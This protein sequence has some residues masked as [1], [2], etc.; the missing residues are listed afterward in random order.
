MEADSKTLFPGETQKVPWIRLLVIGSVLAALPAI[1]QSTGFADYL[2]YIVV[3][4][5]ILGLY[6]MS[7][8]LL[9]GY[10][11]IFSYG[12]ATFLGC[13]AYAV[14]ILM[15]RTSLHIQDAIP[16][17]VAALAV[18]V[19]IGW[20]MGFLCARVGQVAV[21]LVS[22]AFTE[23]IQLLVMSDPLRI[24]NAEDGISGIPRETFLGFLNIKPEVNFYYFVLILLVL[25]Y[26]ALLIIIRKPIGDVFTAIRENPVRVRFL[27]Y[28]IRHYRIAAFMISGF[29]ASLAGALTALHEK[30]VAPEMLSWFLSGDAV[31]FVVL[32][33]PGTLIGP[34]L[35]T[36][37]VVIFQEILSDIFK[38]WV[39]FLGISYIALIMFL[40]KGLF[41]LFDRIHSRRPPPLEN[42]ET[43]EARKV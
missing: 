43:V 19:L 14:A 20:I 22:F 10:S 38:N 30:A 18:G 13:G 39:I 9:L 6:A 12:H 17:L 21:F 42:T 5:M 41:P 3:R 1:F 8:D 25:S 33:G 4:M 37:I 23:S 31:L 28:R 36:M 29:F 27:G 7:Y 15:V 11:G 2:T 16:G 34:I 24:T 26:L 35:G 32:G 40:P